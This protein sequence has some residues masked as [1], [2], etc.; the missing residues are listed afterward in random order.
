MIMITTIKN[1]VFMSNKNDFVIENN[2]LIRYSGDECNVTVPD[3]IIAIN[4]F[5]FYDMHNIV[6]ITL[7][8]SLKRIENYAFMR[9]SKLAEIKLPD[10]LTDIGI[11]AFGMCT[12]LKRIILPTSLTSLKE[13]AF[14]FCTSFES[15][16]I[17]KSVTEIGSGVFDGCISLSEITVDVDNPDYTS[18][19]GVLYN[20]DVSRMIAYPEGKKETR[21]SFPNT[22]TSICPDALKNLKSI[23][24]ITMSNSLT[25][26]PD[27]AF[28]D[29]RNLTSVVLPQSILK[30][31]KS[32]FVKCE[33]LTSIVLP[34]NISVIA[35]SVF[36]G[37]TNLKSIVLPSGLKEI[38][39]NAF[40]GCASLKTVY[41]KGEKK[42]FDPLGAQHTDYFSGK[43]SI[44]DELYDLS[45]VERVYCN[46]KVT[47]EDWNDSILVADWY[48]YSEDAPTEDGNFWRYVNGVPTRW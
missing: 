46:G 30:I 41:Y 5:A 26:I 9:C 40:L 36:E 39:K 20:K 19:D 34:D 44:N 22:I 13:E 47:V 42:D 15:V 37:C 3:H 35:E 38:Q 43:S 21:F 1:G 25:E 11:A 32:A 33:N 2:T 29:F 16:A 4:E 45:G 28:F 48:Y 14:L 12:S 7:P 10:F 6:K 31:G 17:P 27:S 23:H 8:E 24:S 18:I